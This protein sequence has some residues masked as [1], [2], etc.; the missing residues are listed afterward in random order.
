MEHSHNSEG[1]IRRYL[2]GL[3]EQQE[4]RQLEERLLSDNDYFEEL[5]ITEDELIDDY[6]EGALP[7]REREK[8]EHYFLVPPERQR[9]VSFAKSLKK[10]VTVAGVK[11]SPPSGAKSQRPI[12]WNRLIPASLNMK[13]PALGLSLAALLIIFIGVSWLVVKNLSPQNRAGQ[14]SNA[15]AV[16]LTP[17]LVRGAGEIKRVTIPPDVSTVQLQLGLARDE[18][19][20]YQAV[21]L[22]DEGGEIFVADKLK[23]VTAAGARAIAFDLPARLLSSGDYQV[24]LSG[25]ADG[26]EPENV[27]KYYF[28]VALA[29]A[30]P[31]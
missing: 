1:L 11:E 21:V 31:Q 10:Y 13:Q 15:V 20:S 4:Q 18:Y 12:F 22:T 7:E 29:A 9:K 25:L 26:G 19:Q 5:L 16:A 17:G 28:R 23:P 8:F 6:L 30:R 24:K 27:G 14:G 2:L 3:L